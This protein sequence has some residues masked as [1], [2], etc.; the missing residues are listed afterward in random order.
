[1]RKP[2][3]RHIKASK[4]SVKINN[5]IFLARLK[6]HSNQVLNRIS[7]KRDSTQKEIMTLENRPF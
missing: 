6:M 2:I 7:P 3:N 5:F 1:M 4:V